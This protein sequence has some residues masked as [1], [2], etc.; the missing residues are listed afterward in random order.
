LISAP[1]T[2]DHPT[3]LAD[4]LELQALASRD[5]QARILSLSDLK[6]ITQD[7][8][9]EDIADFDADVDAIVSRVT[10]EIQN[11]IEILGESYPFRINDDGT[12]LTLEN[13][14]PVGPA[15]YIFCL[16]MSHITHSP[17][18]E[19]FDLATEAQT[20][21]NIFQIC[22]TLSA[23]G[24]CDGPAVSFGW[25][26]LDQTGFAAKLEQTYAAFGDGKPRATPLP[27]AAPHIKDG[28]IDVIAWR[29][30]V[31]HLP[32]TFYLLG[33]VASGHNWKTKTV[34][35]DIDSFHWAWFE[36]QPTSQATGAMFVPFCVTDPSDADNSIN[37][38][39]LISRMQFITKEFGNFIYRYRLPFYAA[40]AP[41]V[42]SQGHSV[43]GLAEFGRVREWNNAL[44]DRLTEVVV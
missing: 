8:E 17:L 41:I 34:L 12:L 31:D 26:R 1:S 20:G 21:R 19:D 4:W 23:A 42:F 29:P 11:R 5:Q 22:A 18:L 38:D 30:A 33:Q 24:W 9:A 36:I 6:D 32:G 35:K 3:V 7:S 39:I 2:E 15:V 28:G 43:E 13:T 10:S 27:G 14:H 16:L 40:R 44:R 25:P 37:Q